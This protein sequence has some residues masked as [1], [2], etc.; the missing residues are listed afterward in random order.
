MDACD[1]AADDAVGDAD[2][3]ATLSARI[4]RYTAD[5]LRDTAC[6][7][8]LDGE[9]TALPQRTAKIGPDAAQ[10]LTDAADPVV[11]QD[12]VRLYARLLVLRRRIHDA[13]RGFATVTAYVE[14]L[15]MVLLCVLRGWRAIAVLKGARA[16]LVCTEESLRAA[17]LRKRNQ[18]VEEV[19]AVYSRLCPPCPPGHGQGAEEEP[20]EDVDPA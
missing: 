6:F 11:S 9:L 18:L 13:W 1:C 19:M 12:V 15:C 14:C 10:L 7:V 5:V 3:A 8:S 20:C 17:C 16:E 2:T 4:A